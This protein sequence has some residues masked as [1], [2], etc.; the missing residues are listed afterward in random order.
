MGCYEETAIVVSET[1][2]VVIAEAYAAVMLEQFVNYFV[3]GLVFDIHL[4]DMCGQKSGR[5]ISKTHEVPGSHA[6]VPPLPLL[7]HGIC[8]HDRAFASR[9]QRTYELEQEQNLFHHEPNKSDERI[10]RD[11]EKLRSSNSNVFIAK[12]GEEIEI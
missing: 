11:S 7:D 1:A 10:E 9:V 5:P 3:A 6:F 4:Q 12:Q 2:I 8:S